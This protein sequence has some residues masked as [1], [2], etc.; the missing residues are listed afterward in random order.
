ML[1]PA[2]CLQDAGRSAG[3]PAS[4][5]GAIRCAA[6]AP[7]AVPLQAAHLQRCHA[8]H[9]PPRQ[10]DGGARVVNQHLAR[11]ACGNHTS[12]HVRED[13]RETMEQR[14]KCRV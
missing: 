2:H 5:Q 12:R 6:A 7:A 10:L 3:R 13:R 9:V 1:T 4:R 11:R 8:G 14:G